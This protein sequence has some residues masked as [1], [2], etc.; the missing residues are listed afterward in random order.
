MK[1]FFT[2]LLALGAAGY[3]LA[4]WRRP[5]ERSVD[6]AFA[7]TVETLGGYL[8]RNYAD[9]KIFMRRDAHTKPHGCLRGELNAIE[10][11][12]AFSAPPFGRPTKNLDVLIR[13]SNGQMFYQPDQEPDGRGAALK[14]FLDGANA[15]TLDFVMINDSRF[16]LRNSTDIFYFYDVLLSEGMTKYFLPDVW[17][18]F[19]WRWRAMMIAAE[20]GGATV[21]S[22]FE[23]HYYTMSAYHFGDDGDVKLRLA[24][25]SSAS[26]AAHSADPDYMRQDFL[27]RSASGEQCFQLQIQRKPVG[28]DS[29]D[30]SIKWDEKVSPYRNIAEIKF[31][32][33]D[34]AALDKV[35]E[36]A[37]FSPDHVT[38]DIYPIGTL[39]EVRRRVYARQSA[40]RAEYNKTLEERF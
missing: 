40:K 32:A 26:F 39:N 14:I 35:C 10:D 36:A 7:K 13:F 15:Q 29:D 28:V 23:P 30:A 24:N 16:F 19:T 18:P 34:G 27:K 25:C 20:L 3:V 33:Q 37:S 6:E 8:D 12:A 4:E 17:N 5:P 22:V 9:K 2:L 38:N 21:N 11:A 31:P 1:K